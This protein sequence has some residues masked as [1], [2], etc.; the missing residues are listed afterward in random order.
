MAS[1]LLK[2][3]FIMGGKSMKR[4]AELGGVP[5]WIR[6]L[7]VQFEQA[8]RESQGLT[9][10]ERTRAR[11]EPDEAREPKWRIKSR[12]ESTSH[13]IRP[14][15]LNS[16]NERH[17]DR[18]KLHP[19]TRKSE[20]LIVE[21]Q[22][23]KSVSVEELWYAGLGETQVLLAALNIGSRGFFWFDMPERLS[24]FYEEIVDL[25]AEDAKVLVER[26]PAVQIDWGHHALTEEVLRDVERCLAGMPGAHDRHLHARSII[27]SQDWASSPAPT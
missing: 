10:V 2:A 5:A 6:W 15:P 24:R 18:F 8:V 27:T 4:L 22:L 12:F 9:E 20:Q 11:P 17:G 13:S 21:V 7:R 19:V 26:S 1:A 14:R 3:G 25:E 23:P 16:W